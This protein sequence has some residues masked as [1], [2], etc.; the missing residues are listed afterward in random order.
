[1]ALVLGNHEPPFITNI[2]Q[3]TPFSVVEWGRLLPWP[4][5][6]DTMHDDRTIKDVCCVELRSDNLSRSFCTVRVVKESSLI[7]FGVPTM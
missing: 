5:N 3:L 4:P 7:L 6:V 2:S 1:M